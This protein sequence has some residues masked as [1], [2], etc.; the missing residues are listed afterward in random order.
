MILTFTQLPDEPIDPYALFC[1]E[2]E[3]G[4]HLEVRERRETER[5]RQRQTDRQ[6]DRQTH[7]HRHTHTHTHTPIVSFQSLRSIA[8]RI[9]SN[10]Q[11]RN[12]SDIGRGRYRP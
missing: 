12:S 4:C 3:N 7:T 9:E 2:D 6:T 5:E 11:I 10:L 8:T 1:G